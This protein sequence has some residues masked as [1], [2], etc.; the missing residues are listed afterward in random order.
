MESISVPDKVGMASS[1]MIMINRGAG[2][3]NR[4]NNDVLLIGCTL[5]WLNEK[6]MPFSTTF[7]RIRAK[8]LIIA[9]GSTTYATVI[10]LLRCAKKYLFPRNARCAQKDPSTFLDKNQKPSLFP[11][12]LFQFLIPCHR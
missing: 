9:A 7:I 8:A 3:G 4:G 6:I 2:N 5:A 1:G 11:H 12:S 10:F